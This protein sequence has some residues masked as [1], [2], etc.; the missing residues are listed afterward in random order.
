MKLRVQDDEVT[1]NVFNALKY[2]TTSDCCFCMHMIEAKMSTHV[3]HYDPLKTSL[4]Y[5][6]LAESD[7]VEVQKCVAWMNSFSSYKR[8]YFKELGDSSNHGIP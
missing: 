7:D 5:D 6:D 4:I 8:R 2:P 3:D 1:L